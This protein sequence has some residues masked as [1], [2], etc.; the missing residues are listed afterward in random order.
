M[1]I[2]YFQTP[3]TLRQRKEGILSSVILLC[4]AANYPFPLSMGFCV[5][6]SVFFHVIFF[7]FLLRITILLS[8]GGAIKIC[9]FHIP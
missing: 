5:N 3:V 4:V 9:Q 7:T 1:S 8:L 2:R 6:T